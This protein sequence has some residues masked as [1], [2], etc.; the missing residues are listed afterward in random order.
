M[1]SRVDKSMQSD[2][3]DEL[4][5]QRKGKNEFF[6][7]GHDS[8]F[9]HQESSK[10]TGLKYF[11]PDPKY[12]IRVNLQRYSRPETVT[13]VTSTGTQQKFHRVGYFEFEIDGRKLR[14]QAYR[15][16]ERVDNELFIAFKDGTSGK[17]SYGAARYLDLEITQDD[18]YEIDFNYAYNPYCAYSADYVCPLPPREN[19]LDIEIR[20]GEKN[21]H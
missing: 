10:F 3:L 17:E 8:P 13:L 11:A 9:H 12:R 7:T 5:A 4:E 19:W 14:L 1:V 16:A 20:A 18:S 15:S 2:W 6:R 21:Y